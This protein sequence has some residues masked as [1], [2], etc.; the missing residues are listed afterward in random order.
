MRLLSRRLPANALAASAQPTR[1]YRFVWVSEEHRTMYWSLPKCGSSTIRA[2]MFDRDRR[3]SLL[4][5]QQ[6]LDSYFKFTFV[7]NLWDRMVS[8]WKMFTRVPFRIRQIES[9]TDRDVSEFPDFVD[10]AWL[11]PNHHWQPQ[12]LFL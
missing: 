11:Q 5:P 10:F 1:L 4:N 7:R 12:A 8:N 3:L 6:S 2:A 9:M